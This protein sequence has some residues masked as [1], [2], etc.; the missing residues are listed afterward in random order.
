M[1]LYFKVELFFHTLSTTSMQNENLKHQGFQ[2]TAVCFLFIPCILSLWHQ[3]EW[4]REWIPL[5]QEGTDSK[6]N[7]VRSFNISSLKKKKQI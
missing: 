6:E 5:W 4:G 2:I 1:N 7:I 3:E